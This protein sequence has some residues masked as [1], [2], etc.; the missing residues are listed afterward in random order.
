MSD[1]RFA[2]VSGARRREEV[3]AYLPANFAVLGEGAESKQYGWDGTS[4]PIIRTTTFYVI[5]GYDD[6][7]WTLDGY[8]IPRL[9]SGLIGAREVSE[10]TAREVVASSSSPDAYIGLPARR[11][12]RI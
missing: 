10:Q 9:A 2:F 1:A 4:K 6:H 3:A 11:E 12:E 7:G 5:G 8:V